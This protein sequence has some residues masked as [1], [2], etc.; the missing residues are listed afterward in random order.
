MHFKPIL[1]SHRAFIFTLTLL[2]LTVFFSYS[3]AYC[4]PDKPLDLTKILKSL[5]PKD[6]VSRPIVNTHKSILSIAQHP[7]YQK[8]SSNIIRSP[9]SSFLNSTDTSSRVKSLRDDYKKVGI[10]P[11]EITPIT[12]NTT[13]F[14]AQILFTRNEVESIIFMFALQ[15]EKDVLFSTLSGPL[16]LKNHLEKASISI[17]QFCKL[18]VENHHLSNSASSTSNSESQSSG[19]SYLYYLIFFLAASSL[20]LFLYF[21]YNR[22]KNKE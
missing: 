1:T 8:L 12:N 11:K 13:C 19:L 15:H 7:S 22:N 2:L 20:I 18:S 3:H 17:D 4:A 16:E 6:W 21:F 10:F 9:F 5:T 14:S